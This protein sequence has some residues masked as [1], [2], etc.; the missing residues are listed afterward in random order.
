MP[1]YFNPDPAT[2]EGQ[3]E[4]ARRKQFMAKH[5]PLAIHVARFYCRRD[6]GCLDDFISAAYLGLAYAAR[7]F[8]DT[9][10]IAPSTYIWNWCRREILNEIQER[11]QLI[12]IP[13][14]LVKPKPTT[15]QR[16]I[17]A[18]ERART[19]LSLTRAVMY[20]HRHPEFGLDREIIDWHQP[21]HDFDEHPELDALRLAMTFLKP[22]QRQILEERSNGRTLLAIGREL[23][24]T[25]ER[26]RQIEQR[27]LCLLRQHLTRKSPCQR[28]SPNDMQANMPH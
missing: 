20:R 22:R 8:D 3:T 21:D 14:H 18:A 10:G 28:H 1:R 2:Q 11:D 26:V 12:H 17:E 5:V 27:A 16:M 7:G 9:R 6:G 19:V 25:R 23:G 13:R 15:P 4:I 24:L